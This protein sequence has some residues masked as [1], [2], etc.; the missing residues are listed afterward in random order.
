M[1]TALNGTKAA[2]HVS[3]ISVGGPAA[4]KKKESL[5]SASAFGGDERHFNLAVING[6]DTEVKQLRDGENVEEELDPKFGKAT[7]SKSAPVADV[8]RER[9]TSEIQ[10]PNQDELANGN[11]NHEAGP[12][13]SDSTASDE[14][15]SHSSTQDFPE[16][17]GPA[18]SWTIFA[19][20]YFQVKG[21]HTYLC[22]ALQQPLLPKKDKAD[23]LASLAGWVTIL[24][25]MGDL[26]DSD[27]GENIDVAGSAPPIISQV[28][29][30]FHKKYTK[31]DVDEA[32]KKYSEL[33]KD[34]SHSE[35]RNLPFLSERVSSVLEK[36]QYV[37]ALGI[38]KPELRDEIFCQ[39]CK[40]LTNNPSRNS[41]VRGWV[42]L[43]LLAG[44]FTPTEKF[45]PCFLHF[46]RE[47]SPIFACRVERLVRRTAIV[48]TR[49]YPPS[50]LEFQ[51]SKNCKPIL[52]PMSMMNGQR[53]IVEA[54]SASS[55]QEL[56]LQICHKAGLKDSSGFSIYI[57]LMQRISCLGNGLH[58]VM[59]AVAECEQ[60]TRQMG[61][62]ESS[63]TWRLY[64]RKEYFVPWHNPK[65]DPEATDLIYQQVMRGVSVGE[66]KCEKDEDMAKLAA[67]RYF[68]EN[69][70]N[71]DTT[72]LETFLTSWLPESN[73]KTIDLPYWTTKVMEVL[74]N[75]ITKD[76]NKVR[77]LK[78][79]VVNFAK[80]KWHSVFSRF[81][82]ASKIQNSTMTWHNV[83][84]GLN[85]KGLQILDEEEE[86]KCYVS[87]IEITDVSKGRHT[88]TISTLRSEDFVVHSNHADD[89]YLLV[90][91]FMD[92]L[93]RRSK[94][95]IAV[96]DSTQIEGAIGV[97]LTKGD[98]VELEQPY[99]HFMNEDIYSATCVR[100]GKLTM[101]PR[102]LI[103]V[104]PTVER[105]AH[106]TLG[107]LTVQLRK[108]PSVF[109]TQRCVQREH[110]LQMYS[111]LHFR[112]SSDNAVTKF[113]SKASF[114]SSKKEK[115]QTNWQ[116]QKEPIKKPLLR[117]T[118][119]KEE[120]RRA[121][122][123]SF[124]SIQ[125]YM[126]ESP[127]PDQ[128]SEMEL[129]NENIIE[130]AMR[131]RHMR[132]EIYCQIIK[133]LTNNPNKSGED[134][135]WRLLYLLCTCAVPSS[136]LFDECE[137]F[138]RGSK[139]HLA[140]KCL[141]RLNLTK[142]DGARQYPPHPMEHVAMTNKNNT[143]K[144][145]IGFPF[146]QQQDFD[147]EVSSR[148][149]DVKRQ[150]MDK[151][152]LD[153]PEEYGLCFG[154]K[155]RV[156]SA[157]DGEYF[158]DSLT[159]VEI[160]WAKQM[161]SQRS[162]VTEASTGSPNF[163]APTAVH[164]FFLKK[165]WVNA[166]P[167]KNRNADSMFHFPQEVPNYLRG[168]HNCSEKDAGRLAAYIYR[169]QFGDDIT[170]LSDFE[171]N[172]KALIPH[173]LLEKRI[174]NEW[175]QTVKEEIS[176]TK[177]ANSNDAK[178]AFL[179]IIHQWPTYG[180]V[181]F[182]VKQR[183]MKAYPKNVLF[184]VNVN[185]VMFLDVTSKNILAKYE[186]SE[187]P[188]WAYDE[189]SF[190]LIVG[191]G[192]SSN[193]IYMET[194]LGHNMDDIIMSYVAWM[195]NTHI[196]KRPSYAGVTVDDAIQDKDGLKAG[197]L[198]CFEHPHVANPKLQLER[199]ESAVQRV[200][201]TPLDE[202]V[203]AH[204]RCCWAVGN[205]DFIEAYGCQ[206]VVVQAFTKFFQSQKDE[207]WSLPIMFAVCLDLRKFA[208]SADA[209]AQ[210]KG[211]GK[212]GERLEKAAELL[213]GCFRVCAADNRASV[214]DTKKWGMLNLVNQLFKVYFKINKLHLCKP[215]IRAIDS[216]P[217]KDRFPLAQQVTFRY[218]VGRKAMFDSDF[219]SADE[220]L[221]FAFTRCHR[222]SRKNKRMT[223]IYLL[224][225][226]MLLGYMPSQRVL[227]KYDLLQFAEVAQAVSSGN[228]L[229]LN[230][231]LEKNEAFFI[232]CGIYLILEKLKII[233]YRNLFKKVYL[234]LNTHQLPIDAF[235]T[236][237]RMMKVDDIDNDETACIIANLIYENKIKGYIS[238]QHQ[239]LVVSKQNA[240]PKLSTVL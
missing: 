57:T 240:F 132:D 17:S 52:I 151:F 107:M 176:K 97:S 135:G 65:D 150:V 154:L 47:S 169:A 191:E 92:G 184:A 122:C 95:G 133:Q 106:D 215:L 141:T 20:S 138:M 168:Y 200:F 160:F 90:N 127:I 72:K 41:T 53:L 66:Y 14:K 128:M 3:Q 209:Q 89:L 13:S 137:Q 174:P 80:E 102:D 195:M 75:D 8:V 100:T 103:Y 34:P 73:K 2:K 229:S 28:K 18:T 224:P 179:N 93:R 214:E 25:I 118:H 175:K 208:N 108:D 19:Q 182:T 218:Y 139:H 85:S 217:L 43:H 167:G 131:S 23:I 204:I 46:L 91:K 230:N 105:P 61:M 219:K 78:C 15:S 203:A 210:K 181:F 152:D 30:S 83:I 234:I 82:D 163:T 178:L 145:T 124:L 194:N 140:Q 227:K 64:F 11:G 232:K 116:Y 21:S 29:Q 24:R 94:Y 213:M 109:P 158:L 38:Y 236:A 199:P 119:L 59:D 55:V 79:D 54:D 113:L 157:P 110:T 101:M 172:M 74:Q 49:G 235:T 161:R 27:Q 6:E 115:S 189:Q 222:L 142:S 1:A 56:A 71:V 125:Q 81:Y 223:L 192:Q 180:S 51:A 40:Q 10:P 190:T 104:I 155:D 26:P 196:Q 111:K 238:H 143:I 226:K 159:N 136:E 211:R 153:G 228:L 216:L 185:G 9:L 162:S 149:A 35:V 63:S 166:V 212:A 88:V 99:E 60:H 77:E 183:S 164:V 22:S 134:K 69:P 147:V 67:Q 198:L 12:A 98:L 146:Q 156:I 117:R 68:I 239:K 39:V 221:T 206:A 62:R 16:P 201:D 37:C 173:P 50:W 144:I 205:H 123:R 32:Y 7:L 76:R 4:P 177:G 33:F 126:G 231:A 86:V 170:A 186:Y 36:V 70:G 188:N 130:P 233:T 148:V 225:V 202:L 5:P 84:L 207:N 96:Q 48:G 112:H 193:K 171:A 31:R 237:L 220:F 121:S 165:L 58:R 120:L 129:S 187:I 87:F 42:L 45:F 114:K 197:D 44:C